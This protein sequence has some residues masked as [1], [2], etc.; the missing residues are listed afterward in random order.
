MFI[1]KFLQP[2]VR[3]VGC[4][5]VVRALPPGHT[6][7]ASVVCCP[8]VPVGLALG[9]R[10]L[11]DMRTVSSSRTSVCPDPLSQSRV[12]LEVGT[13]LGFRIVSRSQ[14]MSGSSTTA[15]SGWYNSL[16]ESGSVHLCEQYLMGLQQVT[17]FP[18]WV[19]IIMSTVMVRTLITLPLATYQVVIIAKVSDRGHDSFILMFSAD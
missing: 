13:R 14:S 11:S 19:S 8:E 10:T 15:S 12:F 2:P 3:R 9:V 16:A 6:W 18:W 5:L 7:S 1:V 4:S 17:G